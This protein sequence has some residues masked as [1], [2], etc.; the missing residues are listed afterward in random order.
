MFK[1]SNS[2]IALLIFFISIGCE[3]KISENDLNEYK[4]LMD[5]INNTAIRTKWNGE[6]LLAPV[7]IDMGILMDSTATLATNEIKHVRDAVAKLESVFAK[8]ELFSG[9]AIDTS[10]PAAWA[11]KELQNSIAVQGNL[12]PELLPGDGSTLKEEVENLLDNLRNGPFIFNLGHGI[13]PK[14]RPENIQKLIDLIR[15]KN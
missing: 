9:L 8:N 11:K 3:E 4:A 10:I 13:T 2:I 14:A 5:E 7:S 12:D 15:S 6:R 1:I